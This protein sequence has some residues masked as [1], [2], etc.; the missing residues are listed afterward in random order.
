LRHRGRFIVLDGPDGSGKTTQARLLA[1]RLQQRGLRVLLLREPGGTAAGEAI[2]Q[3]LLEKKKIAL[4]PLA[5]TFLFQAAR[6]QLVSEVMRPALARGEWIISDRFWLSTLVY[7][8]LVGGVR[9]SVVT[10]LSALATGGL[11][12]DRC[13]VIWVPLSVG[14]QRRS[15]RAADRMESKGDA[16]LHAVSAAYRREALRHPRL[17]TLVDGRGTVD[18]VQARIWQAVEPMLR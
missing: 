4:S 18:G 8:G 16:F 11:K 17:Y 6:A 14:A 1:E 15:H 10:E 5:E 3:V 12:P 2:R 7:Q 9:P 13:F